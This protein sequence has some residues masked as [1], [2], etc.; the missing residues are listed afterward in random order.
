MLQNLRQDYLSVNYDAVDKKD[1]TVIPVQVA[2][3]VSR[4]SALFSI[5]VANDLIVGLQYYFT[6]MGFSS[7]NL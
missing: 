4:L 1:H 2:I 3:T 6:N 5:Y 7:S